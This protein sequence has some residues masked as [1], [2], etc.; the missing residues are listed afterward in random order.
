MKRFISILLLIALP[1][2][3]VSAFEFVLGQ[4]TGMGN[5]LLLSHSSPS[6]LLSAPSGGLYQNEWRVETGFNRQFDMSEFDQVFV[7]A[8]G[9]WKK[10]LSAI[11][12][13]QFGEGDLYS[14]RIAKLSLGWQEQLVS[15]GL[16]G[17]VL[18]A[19]FGGHYGNLSAAS[20]GVGVGFRKHPY[21]AAVS[22]DNLT[23]PRLER[24]SPRI[25]PNYAT[26]FEYVSSRS[27]S[28]VGRMT[29]QNR[30]TPQF[31]IGQRIVLGRGGSLL[32]GFSTAP[33]Q[34]GGGV[35]LAIKESTISYTVSYHPVLGLSHTVA[36]SYGSKLPKAGG[37]EFK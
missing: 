8:G 27:M 16:T 33:I 21:Y 30:E 20:F 3:G 31:A 34:F 11:G 2:P 28:V 23:S 35:D 24:G 18:M 32:W 37:D 4:G 6:M 26:Y 19:S 29:F 17:S 7:A 9:R 12:F 36:V 14:E 1:A 10:V 5:G 15:I 22:A 25:E 13:S